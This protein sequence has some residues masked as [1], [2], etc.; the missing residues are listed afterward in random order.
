MN[1]YAKTKK[2]LLIT[3]IPT[4]YRIPLFNELNTQLESNGVKLKVVFGA[5]AY[6]RRKW[7]IDMSECKFDYVVMPS[8]SIR[9]ANPE[10]SS[11][12]YSGL[13]QIVSE[14]NPSAVITNGFS[15]ATTKLWLR[16]WFVST[17][18]IIWSGDI[19]RKNKPDSLLRKVH[20]KL[21]I[22][23]ASGFV[24]YGTKAKEYLL[25][26]GADANK[27]KIGINTVDTQFY[28]SKRLESQNDSGLRDSIKH[29]L[30]VGHLSPRK[31]VLRILKVIESLAKYRSDFIIGIVGDGENVIQLKK[32]VLHKQLGKFIKFH[33]FKQKSDIAA[34]MAQ[35]D[36]FLFQTDFDI[37]GLVLVEAMAAGL[38]CI[39]SVY[40][41]A[42]QDLIEDGVTGFAMDFSEIARV[43][44]KINWLL[45]NPHLAK[46]IGQNASRFV[47]QNIS[48]EKA[49]SGFVETIRNTMKV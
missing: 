26:L 16:H 2:V 3:N 39:A 22:A 13:Y 5:L 35:A 24:A 28:A 6:A 46:Q 44:E 21:L 14:F 45:A 20:R 42:T 41:G 10:K 7:A 19:Y 49:A 47:G 34:S 27:V 25:Y 12:T 15:V 18:Y 30:Y 40:A 17:P 31:N 8:K 1:A 38:P 36:C 32:Y 23:R 11:F 29:L 43:A 37:W 9:Y 48:L 33:G 4:P